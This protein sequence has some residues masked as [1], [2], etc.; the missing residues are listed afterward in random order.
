ML[1]EDHEDVIQSMVEQGKINDNITHPSQM[2]KGAVDVYLRKR[3]RQEDEYRTEWLSLLTNKCLR[4][5]NPNYINLDRFEDW[6]K[7]RK[8]YKENFMIEL[9]MNDTDRRY[10][11][12]KHY[13]IF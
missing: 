3:L 12:S 1:N 7:N 10:A 8:R 13:P 5:R 4:Y 2:R 6:P 9:L 11:H